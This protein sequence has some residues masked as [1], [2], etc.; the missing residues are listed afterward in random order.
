MNIWGFEGNIAS[1]T[2][3]ELLQI[4][5][6]GGPDL[7]HLRETEGHTLYD[8][9][10]TTITATE[11]DRP[12]HI[13]DTTHDGR[14]DYGIEECLTDNAGHISAD[15]EDEC[16]LLVNNGGSR[17]YCTPHSESQPAETTNPTDTTWRAILTSTNNL[18]HAGTATNGAATVAPKLPRARASISATASSDRRGSWWNS[19]S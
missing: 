12:D 4:R 3:N 2:E 18:T 1:L 9:G 13:Q 8:E 5:H 17:Y 7:V 14:T 16:R 11:V 10:Y 15:Y 19:A 6:E